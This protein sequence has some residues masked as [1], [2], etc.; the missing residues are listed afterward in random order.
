MDRVLDEIKNFL[1]TNKTSTIAQLQVAFRLAYKDVRKALAELE[2][3]GI[4]ARDGGMSFRYLDE[5]PKKSKN[6]TD[7]PFLRLDIP[8][9][10]SEMRNDPLIKDIMVY[11]AEKGPDQGRTTLVEL[12]IRFRLTRG[13]AYG[14]L[15][16]MTDLG[17]FSEEGEFMLS[18][19]D[20]NALVKTSNTSIQEQIEERRRAMM[21]K[22]DKFF[23]ESDKE[24]ENEEPV[25]EGSEDERE[26]RKALEEAKRRFFA[27]L[28]ADCRSVEGNGEEEERKPKKKSSAPRSEKKTEEG[29]T[30]LDV[31]ALIDPATN[32][33]GEKKRGTTALSEKPLKKKKKKK[34]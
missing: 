9:I 23:T 30:Q 5:K 24:E 25:E 34:K 13:R 2:E 7:D 19:R 33:K 1:A 26:D 15:D 14:L 22:W 27:R 29:A 3:N 8:L 4:V 31:W 6:Q 10:V 20:C 11:C 12:Q 32:K 18:E 28:E 16:R 17:L 21:R